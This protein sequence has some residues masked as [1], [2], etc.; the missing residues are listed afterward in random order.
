MYLTIRRCEGID[1]APAEKIP[2]AR[3]VI[4]VATAQTTVSA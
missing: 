2:T 3:D 4:A 1:R